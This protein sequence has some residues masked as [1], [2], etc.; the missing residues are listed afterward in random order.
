[1]KSFRLIRAACVFAIAGAVRLPSASLQAQGKTST[2]YPPSVAV[3]GVEEHGRFRVTMTGFFVNTATVD[4][5]LLTDG[6][7]D[8]VYALV[9]FAEL[10]SNNRVF[11]AIQRKKSLNYGDISGSAT[12]AGA[13]QHRGAGQG[14]VQLGRATLTGGLIAS[15]RFPAIGD[16]PTGDPANAMA[17]DRG[18]FLPMI[19]WEGEL[20]RGGTHPNA[21]VLL[22]TIWEN[23]NIPGM[24]NMYQR[25]ADTFIRRFAANSSRFIV[26]GA[27]RDLMEQVDTVGY[28]TPQRNDFDRPIG[29]GGQ[30]YDPLSATPEPATFIPAVMLLTYSS[31]QTAIASNSATPGRVEVRYADGQ[32]YGP[33]NYTIFLVI[34]RLAD[35]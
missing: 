15:D 30:P 18:R 26:G 7:G 9:N 24:L 17:V 35:R 19:L 4:G 2:V 13:L 3:T 25:Q 34:E 6:S 16:R 20:R 5:V 11:G 1:L 8:E 33:G 10:F 12:P 28:Y 29:V 21:V 27:R 22:P 23:D 31:A 14:T 32:R